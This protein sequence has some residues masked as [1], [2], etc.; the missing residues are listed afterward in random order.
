MSWATTLRR[1]RVYGGSL[2]ALIDWLA[3][4]RSPFLLRGGRRELG[5]DECSRVVRIGTHGLGDVGRLRSRL[6]ER[7][8]YP[9]VVFGHV[10]S[11]KSGCLGERWERGYRCP[12]AKSAR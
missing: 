6:R 3:A 4:T 2:R 12:N 8:L 10:L 11:D 1:H 9:N 5:L 7:T